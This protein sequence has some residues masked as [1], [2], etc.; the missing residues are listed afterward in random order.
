MWQRGGLRSEQVDK[1]DKRK[2]REQKLRR[3]EEVRRVK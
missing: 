3:E 1:L 2:V